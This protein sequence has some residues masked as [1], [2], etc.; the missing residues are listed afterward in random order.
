MTAISVKLQ[1]VVGSKGQRYRESVIGQKAMGIIEVTT[2]TRSYFMGII[3][4]T[5]TH[6][7]YVL[8]AGR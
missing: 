4:H 7:T 2:L 3:A 6:E 5:S 8:R 1:G